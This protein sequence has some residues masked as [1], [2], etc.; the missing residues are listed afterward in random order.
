MFTY[1][2]TDPKKKY[3]IPS[4]NQWLN[5]VFNGEEDII[6]ANL[7]PLNNLAKNNINLPKDF[8]KDFPKY[9]YQ[10]E[11]LQQIK[12]YLNQNKKELDKINNTP[13]KSNKF[14]KIISC[15]RSYD[16]LRG[17]NG[18]LCQEFGA[19]I[20][21][22]AWLKMYENMFYLKEYLD[23]INKKNGTF[24]TFHIAEAPGNFVLAI[25]HFIKTNYL[26]ITW[27]WL[28]SSYKNIYA[29]KQYQEN[30]STKSDYL[31]DTYGLMRKYPNLWYYGSEGDGDITSSANLISF[32]Q[33]I[34][35]KFNGK[36]DFITSDVKYVPDHYNYDEEE[37]YNI[38]VHLGHLLCSLMCLN[39]GGIMMLKEFTFYESSSVSL[40]Y[41]MDFC[42]NKV[43][44]T[45]PETS[46]G[47]NSEVYIFGIGYK[48]NL[49]EIQITKLLNILNYI[50]YLNTA[51]GSPAI[52]LKEDINDKFVEKI[53]EFSKLL[54]KMQ[55]P[56]IKKNIELFYQYEHTNIN[57]ICD[58]FLTGS[59]IVANEWIK[60][61]NIKKLNPKDRLT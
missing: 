3:K 13:E 8:K 56:Y 43:L 47:A 24:N 35:K 25:N 11:S 34:L 19:E 28:A 41:L 30:S 7:E 18:K 37:N 1:S 10:Y 40:L 38:P 32:K 16:L 2:L 20:V 44:I 52:F 48:D 55:I 4:I 15:Y 12:S 59:E 14:Y 22:N 60:N 45:K 23:K 6:L 49:T 54:A 39:P 50:R 21:T 17:S 5:P 31:G 58:D 53:I 46:K 36:L 61:N 26:N 33:E 42:F 51:E 9:V 57:N 29:N 27:N